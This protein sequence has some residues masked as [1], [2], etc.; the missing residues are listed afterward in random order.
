M[1]SAVPDEIVVRPPASD[2]EKAAFFRLTAGHFIRGTPVDIAAADLRRYVYEAPHADPSWA[3]GVFHG[4]TCLGGYLY[5]ERFLRIG[6]ARLGMG[7]VG[8]VIAHP[9]HR[10]QGIGK[11]LMRDS[12]AYARG[13]GHVMLM[14]HGAPAY[15]QPFGYAD[16]FDATE[17]DVRRADILAHPPSPYRVRTATTA[18]A[19]ATLDLYER[20]FGSHPGSFARS[21]DQETFLIRF[22]ANLDPHDYVQR[23]GLPFSLTVVAVDG[24]NRVRGYLAA[25]WAL[26][27]AF[28]HEVAADDWP[29]TL[30]LLQH[31]AR[32][33]DSLAEPPEQLRW[34][35]PPDS[36]MA[37]L[38][39]DHFTV[40]SFRHARPMANWEA[41]L[42]DP[43]VLI[44]GMVP[45]WNERWRQHRVPWSGTLALTIDDVTRALSISPDGVSL[46]ASNQDI[47]E[48]VSL[49]GTV[50]LPLLFGFRSLEW[51]ATQ[52]GQ[53]I[54]ETLL[55]VL[56]VLFPA[57]TPWIAA[58]DGS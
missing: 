53:E 25:P 36:L 6:A 19:P 54:P 32:L 28:G 10:G 34:P 49:T 11:A 2:E 16:V 42:V 30:A 5:E 3:R 20:H 55:P 50:A 8:V 38:L 18:D 47:T 17:H 40:Q 29:A 1:R 41:S 57:R 44:A 46:A 45:E 48:N 51:A 37:E 39:A 31:H 22:A 9:E 4:D 14:L 23:D 26:L 27:R 24:N 35:L 52:E 13:H 21:V 58:R 33:L 12:F 7:C 15:Y 43:A 56:E